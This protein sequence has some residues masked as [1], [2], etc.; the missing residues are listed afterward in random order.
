MFSFSRP[1]SRRAKR[2]AGSAR[3]H[4][5]RRRDFIVE[6]LEDRRLLTSSYGLLPDQIRTAYG[7]DNT[8]G[9]NQ[10]SFNGVAGTGAGQTIA[11]IDSGDDPNIASD[12]TA[13]DT[14][15]T[16]NASNSGFSL[17]APPSFKVVGQ[18]GGAVPTFPAIVSI[19]ENGTTAT[20]TTAAPETFLP[21]D[22]I[23]ISDTTSNFQYEGQ[24]VPIDT[25]I[26][27][28]QFTFTAP[29]GLGNSSGGDIENSVDAG[30]TSLDV[31]WAHA[32]APGASIVLIEVN[33][34]VPGDTTQ[35]ISTAA[36]MGASV[37]SMSFGG[38]EYQQETSL[39]SMFTNSKTSYILS[40]GDNGA[41][42]IYAASSTNVLA[43][44]ATNLTLN[45]D[46]SYQSE[47]AWCNPATITGGS[48][49]TGT[50]T[51]TT[52][53]PTG[54]GVGQQFTIFNAAGNLVSLFQVTGVNAATT[55]ITAT[56]VL[57]PNRTRNL[58]GDTA[59][60]GEG[61]P[62]TV[63]NGGTTG[64]PSQFETQPAYQAGVVPSSMSTPAG[65][66]TAM[67]TTPDVS[68]VGGTGTPEVIVDSYDDPT[69]PL[70]GA[71]GTSLSAPCWAG[72]VA[73]IDQ[74]LASRGAAPLNT[75]NPTSGLQS[76][77]YQLPSTDF[78]KIT[79]GYN[80]YYSTQSGYDLVTG[81][82]SPVANLLIPDV[83]NDAAPPPPVITPASTTATVNE[84][85]ATLKFATTPTI[86]DSEQPR[87]VGDE[88]KL[89][90]NTGTLTVAGATIVAGANG[91]NS[92]TIQG[93]LAQLNTALAGLYYTSN[94]IQN[95]VLS[96]TPIDPTSGVHGVSLSGATATVAITINP[97][98]QLS[99]IF[100]NTPINTPI[101]IN[102]LADA[103]ISSGSINVSTFQISNDLGNGTLDTSNLDTNGTIIYTPP[104]GFLGG[105][106]FDYTVKSAD[107]VPSNTGVVAIVV[108]PTGNLSGYSYV[109]LNNDGIK[110]SSESGIQGVTVSLT[111]T[112]GNFTFGLTTQTQANGQYTFTG[113]PAGNY[114]I[115]ETEPA[116]FEHGQDTPGTPAPAGPDSSG[117]FA[118][119]TLTGNATSTESGSGYNFAELGLRAQFVMAYLGERA[120]FASSEQT[121]TGF[122]ASTGPI[123]VSL[124]AGINGVLT[125][126]AANSSS[127]SVS[128][129]LYNDN[130]QPLVASPSSTTASVLTYQG[131]PGQPY[132]IEVTG[133]S[134]DATLQTAV[135]TPSYHNSVDPEDVLGLG[136]VTPADA[137][138]LINLLNL[139]GPG[140]LAGKQVPAGMTPDVLGTG[141][142][143]SADV[144]AVINALNGDQ[145]AVQPAAVAPA[146]AAPS[147]VESPAVL[148]AEVAPAEVAPAVSPADDTAAASPAAP[149]VEPA[150]VAVQPT[151]TSSAATPA[152]VTPAVVTSPAS[153]AVGLAAAA[154]AATLGP[155]DSAANAARVQFFASS[156]DVTAASE[157]APAAPRRLDPA[158]VAAVLG[159]QDAAWTGLS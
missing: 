17:S 156:I 22:F 115:T 31:E 62:S 37:V 78:H 153:P 92:V 103:T 70:T 1:R 112:A 52:G 35:A 147:F 40:S 28:T 122:N 118:N 75:S 97:A 5:S 67:R 142:L 68:F 87:S 26:S 134:T 3:K 4:Q 151:G 18:T 41:P 150:A 16:Q 124:D 145:Q 55:S 125:A 82:G 129:T 86:T 98:P 11:I 91:T 51:F 39:D 21:G 69:E 93:T 29:A 45:A 90:V 13:F 157:V 53:T 60:D 107:G 34:L 66:P 10:I 99:N 7:L 102:L 146:A 54:L 14:Y 155:D 130:L 65:S 96:I 128:M 44:G 33:S 141:I 89:S 158:G 126:T 131:R 95:A 2:L 79:V 27:S 47:T 48:E 159:G 132:F 117:V 73:I 110:E 32:M 20:V 71:S 72:L 108:G 8:S 58:V 6:V 144:L 109:D 30:E 113:L 74:G 61:D 81:L 43:V 120:F 15:A 36:A 12:L 116:F 46:N 64:G 50:A 149:A 154:N 9:V 56:D 49:T 80:G 143:E 152:A 133:S 139:L 135:V 76:F 85:G 121:L 63:N 111:G 119:I 23:T 114:T 104:T 123:W 19:V 140:P 77:L 94:G 100:S 136:T 25:V 138:A 105:E 57:H 106:S 148:P 137:L 84:G 101:T 127:G 24:Q 88:L 59:F 83:V 38:A 42:P